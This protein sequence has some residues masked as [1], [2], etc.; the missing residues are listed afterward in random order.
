M[1]HLLDTN[2]C[3]AHLKRPAGLTHYF[4]QYAGRLFVPTPVLSELY[5]WANQRKSPKSLFSRIQTEL[6]DDVTVLDFDKSCAMEFGRLNAQLLARGLT[7][8]PVDLMIASVAI[9]YDLTLVT[10][11]TCDFQ[12]IPGIRL[13][14]WLQP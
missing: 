6:L 13:E 2:I 10:N 14:D 3:S 8:S 11:N 12:S 1:S 9:V 5:T 4:I 7:I